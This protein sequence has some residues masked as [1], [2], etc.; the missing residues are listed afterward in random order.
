MT[1]ASRW[2]A[3]LWLVRHGQSAGNVALEAA[4]AAGHDRIQLEMR[5]AD[6]PLSPQGLVQAQALGTWFANL[7]V[8]QRPEVVLASPYQRARQTAEAIRAAGGLAGASI[9]LCEDERLREREFGVLDR[10]TASGVA[11]LFPDQAEA[12]RL[13][14]KFYHRPPGARAGATSS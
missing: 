11:E 9:A 14:G 8:H 13:L 2:P 4:H 10:L 3:A 1:A 5:D 6:V 12:R 7:P